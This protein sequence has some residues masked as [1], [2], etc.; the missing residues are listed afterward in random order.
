MTPPSKLATLVLKA[1]P[2]AQERLVLLGR[3]LVEHRV[4]PAPERVE[5]GLAGQ[6]VA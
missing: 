6:A 5:G 2:L 4:E 1:Q 3:P